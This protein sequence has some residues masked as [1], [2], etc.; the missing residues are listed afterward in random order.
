M[1]KCISFNAH[2]TKSLS[3]APAFVLLNFGETRI[4][5]IKYLTGRSGKAVL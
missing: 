3:H 4:L 5:H 1:F 2:M